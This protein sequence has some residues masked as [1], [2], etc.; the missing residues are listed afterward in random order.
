MKLDFLHECAMMGLEFTEEELTKIF[1]YICNAGS[2][3]TDSK[4][5]QIQLMDGGK[6]AS[7]TTRFTFKKLHDAILV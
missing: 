7:S 4:D 5:Q 2:K 6:K 1:E 3:G